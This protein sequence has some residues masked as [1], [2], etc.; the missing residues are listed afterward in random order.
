MEDTIT[1]KEYNSRLNEIDKEVKSAQ[2]LLDELV[3]MSN[4]EEIKCK[5][6]SQIGKMIS[7]GKAD[8]FNEE[9]F[10]YIIDRIVIG[11]VRSDG[12]DDPKALHS[13]LNIDNLCTDMVVKVDKDGVLRYTMNENIEG[14]ICNDDTD[15]LCS[16][17]NDN[18]H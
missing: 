12:I 10:N 6:G 14:I 7:E 15:S 9:L 17:Y 5:A 4:K 13:E 3:S 18:A 16:Y 2:K 8:C 1:E 11:G